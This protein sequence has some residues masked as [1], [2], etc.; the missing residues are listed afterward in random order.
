MNRLST[1][2]RA[3]MVG[4]LVEGNSIR[5]TSRLS[6]VAYATVI[7]FVADIGRACTD[8]QDRTLR[9]ITARRIQADEIWAFCYAKDKNIPEHMRGQKGIGSVWTWVAL[10]ADCKLAISWLVGDRDGKAATV[11]LQD[12]ADRL[13]NRVQL[14]TDGHKAY[15]QAVESAF[16]NEIDYAILEKIY[17]TAPDAEKRY[18]PPECISCKRHVLMGKPN[19][20]FVS[21]SYTERQNLTMRMSMRH[22]TRLT[23][24]FSKKIENH[25]HSVALHFM[26]YNFGRVHKTLRV[27]PAM[28]AGIT[29]HVWTLE[30]VAALVDNLSE[31]QPKKRGSYKKRDS[32]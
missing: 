5:A 15:L 4:L 18:S 19:P 16:G 17:G 31:Y 29:D 30:D 11:F 8:Y 13:A 22:F 10:D 25:A 20:E 12:V 26:W 24:A 27:T 28:E 7:K 3:Q 32:N 14:T 21:T 1:E 6:G 23:N 9:N 2:K